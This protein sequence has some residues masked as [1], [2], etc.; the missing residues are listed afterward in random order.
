MFLKSLTIDHDTDLIRNIVFRKGI[1]LIVDETK[2]SDIRE[3][4]NNVGKTTVL[5]LIDFCLGSSGK[6]IYKD[7]EFRAKSNLEVEQYLTN[8][9]VH[10]TLILKED[11][12]IQISKEVKIRRNFLARGEKIIEVNDESVKVKNFPEILKSLI[13]HSDQKKPTFKQIIS[14]NIRDEKNRLLNT[15]KVLHP[16]T[17]S[18]EYEALYLFWLGIDLDVSDRKQKLFAEKKIEEDLQ[19]RLKKESTVSQLQQSLL[20]INGE[21]EELERKKDNLNLNENYEEEVR[22][23]NNAKAEISRISTQITRLELRVELINESAQ[24]LDKEISSVTVDKIR[25]VYEE[26]KVLLPLVHK[27]FEETLEFHNG[28]IREKRKYIT[29]ELPE[30]QSELESL[31]RHLKLE[32]SREKSLSEGLKASGVM[33]DFQDIVVK[34]NQSYENKGAIEEQKRLWESSID[35][36]KLINWDI[37]EIDEGIVSLD[38]TI[39]QRVSEFNKFFSKL[40]D[41]LYGEKYVLSA[42]KSNKGYELNISTLFGNPGTGKKKGEM[43]AFDLS[44]IQFADYL[45][46]E[47]LHFV[48][49]DQIENIHDNQINNILTQFVENHNCQYVLPVLRDKLPDDI[50]VSKF[51]ILSLSQDDKLFKI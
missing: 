4:G 14:K 37:K 25:R 40:S 7:P 46:I 21:I 10:V 41:E 18:E 3:S 6:N 23:L 19:K 8:N 47:C 20:V 1:N 35:K 51:E 36:L 50:D 43:A 38:N 42:D 33:D 31:Q 34:L 44:Y 32:L 12:S 5:R 11:L 28:M 39:Q 2:T 49:Q 30:I 45:G 15:V 24:E 27:T 17:R 13:F 29:N 9:N 26:A 48:L 22:S 16:T